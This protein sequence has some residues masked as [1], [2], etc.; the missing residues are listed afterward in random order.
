MKSKNHPC[1]TQ[2]CREKAREMQTSAQRISRGL[3]L[4]CK[5]HQIPSHSTSYTL[6]Q[7]VLKRPCLFVKMYYWRGNTRRETLKELIWIICTRYRSAPA[8]TYITWAKKWKPGQRWLPQVPQGCPH[9]SR[10]TLNS[11]VHPW[12]LC[13]QQWKGSQRFWETKQNKTKNFRSHAHFWMDWFLLCS[14]C[15]LNSLYILNINPL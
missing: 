4:W 11:N 6:W 10:V 9:E 7:G 3:Y 12:H 15:I 5:S 8:Y 13:N 1:S 14:Y 2:K